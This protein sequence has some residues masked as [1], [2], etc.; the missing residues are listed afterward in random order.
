MPYI[1]MPV[2]AVVTVQSQTELACMC[3]PTFD[4]TFNYRPTSTVMEIGQHTT[5]NTT[6]IRAVLLLHLISIYTSIII[7]IMSIVSIYEYSTHA[8]VIIVG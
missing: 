1:L 5:S 3:R 2:P 6:A 4:S 7:I 8:H